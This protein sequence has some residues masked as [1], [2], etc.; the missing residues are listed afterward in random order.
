MQILSVRGDDLEQQVWA[1]V[2]TFL[3]NRKP[4]LRRRSG[5][6][7][8]EAFGIASG[9]TATAVGTTLSQ[10]TSTALLRS[11]GLFD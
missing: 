1:D 10:A 8:C 3:R 7:S 6:G 9:R 4:V 2:P 11:G 5:T